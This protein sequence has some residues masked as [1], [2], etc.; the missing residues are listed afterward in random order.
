M[1]FILAND[2]HLAREWA[3]QNDLADDGWSVATP[4]KLRA[5]PAGEHADKT[6]LMLEGAERSPDYALV[7]TL[8][9]DRGLA[10]ETRP[11][12]PDQP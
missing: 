10:I 9:R 7:L 3:E 6:L 8:A 2:A 12:A 4:Q 11:V 1:I 5:L